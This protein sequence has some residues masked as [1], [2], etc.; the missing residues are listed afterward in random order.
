MNSSG[1]LPDPPSKRDSNE[2]GA[3]SLA[4]AEREIALAAL[5]VAAPLR[6]AFA[7]RHDTFVFPPTDESERRR[8]SY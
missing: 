7:Y 8:P 4:V 3:L 6:A 1:L 5:E 2:N